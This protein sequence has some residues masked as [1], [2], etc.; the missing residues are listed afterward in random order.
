M[1]LI[2]GNGLIV[3]ALPNDLDNN[4]DFTYPE[5]INYSL[6]PT[7]NS[8]DYWDNLDDPSDINTGDITD[9]NTYIRADQSDTQEGILYNRGVIPTTDNGYNLGGFTSHWNNVYV[10]GFLIKQGTASIS[11]AQAYSAYQYSIDNS[12]AHTDYLLNN[13]NDQTSGNLST[14]KWFLGKIN[15][16]D[17]NSWIDFQDGNNITFNESMLSTIYYN[18]TSA[19]AV[20][21]TI[22][23]GTLEDTQH[24]DGAYDGVTFNFSEEAGS[25]ALDL[26]VNFSR[27]DLITFNNGI[28][29]YKTSSLSGAYPIIQMWDYD[30]STWEDYPYMAESSTFS[31]ISQ[32]IFDATD[33]TILGSQLTHLLVTIMGIK[34]ASIFVVNPVA[35]ELEL[36][37]TEGLSIKYVNKGPILVDQS[38]KLS[39]NLRP[40]IIADTEE[41]DQLQYPE[42]AKP[43][44]R[45]RS[46]SR[47]I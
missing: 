3:G 20:V 14:T 36:L 40:V 38:I 33:P 27:A 29:R 24:P 30:S 13:L 22:D 42:K 7:V 43:R 12:Q 10:S 6:I 35:E 5:I 47:A 11:V 34:G 2:I 45:C 23:G 32:P 21:G 25:P 15:L 17:D 19:E 46:D 26:R 37:A 41:S 8:S 39:S 1:F 31:T 9:D 18:G 16:T 44:S 28:M 4:I